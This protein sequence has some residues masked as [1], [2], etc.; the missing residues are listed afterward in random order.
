MNKT[1][2]I[3]CDNDSTEVSRIQQGLSS[4]D[5][6]NLIVLNDALQ[7]E[8]TAIERQ[9]SVVIVNPEVHA[10]NEYDVCKQLMKDRDIPVLLL[11]AP[12][13]THRAQIDECRTN[14]V[15]T[16]PVELNNL[17]NLLHKHMSVHQTH[18]QREES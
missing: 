3:I 18:G 13:S 11:L 6:F 7:L 8:S 12:D 14:D 17:I 4:H 1:T 15:L 10:F 16:K 5:E 9:P 2:I